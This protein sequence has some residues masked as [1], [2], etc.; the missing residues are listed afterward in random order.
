MPQT[1]TQLA[2]TQQHGINTHYSECYH[3]AYPTIIN[4]EVPIKYWY[5][6][7]SISRENICIILKSLDFKLITPYEYHIQYKRTFTWL[8]SLFHK[9]R[10]HEWYQKLKYPPIYAYPIRHQRNCNSVGFVQVMQRFIMPW[11]TPPPSQ[12]FTRMF[13]WVFVP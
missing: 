3:G 1:N 2:Y 4:I 12:W 6:V 7:L 9:A 11:A 13:G 8:L 5:W 10:T